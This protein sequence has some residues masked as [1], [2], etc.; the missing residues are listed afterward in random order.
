MHQESSDD[1]VVALVRKALPKETVLVDKKEHHMFCEQ[2]IDDLAS[3]RSK[4]MIF[5]MKSLHNAC[6]NGPHSVKRTCDKDKTGNLL[7]RLTSCC[8]KDPEQFKEIGLAMAHKQKH[9]RTT[10]QR[11]MVVSDS[12]AHSRR[13]SFDEGGIH[14]TP[15]EHEAQHNGGKGDS[16]VEG[17]TLTT[18][19][20]TGMCK[21]ASSHKIPAH[22]TN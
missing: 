13:S 4:Y 5:A 22:S 16:N 3:P 11:E 18:P 7:A 20:C 17:P 15:N 2:Q 21:M 1:D 8:A 10:T 12:E 6:H 19:T 14:Q 9:A